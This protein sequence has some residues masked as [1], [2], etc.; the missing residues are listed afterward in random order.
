MVEPLRPKSRRM[1]FALLVTVC[2]VVAVGYG[3][4]A[5]QRTRSES[6]RAV[7]AGAPEVE[8][9]GD[10]AAA[11]A[12]IGKS[13]TVL[14]R[15]EVTGD[16]WAKTA[17][18]P[19][20]A[21]AGS[22]AIVPLRCRRL[23]F[24]GGRGLC[25]ADEPGFG[26]SHEV[27]VFGSDFQVTHKLALSGLPSRARVSP[28]GRY[29]ATTV[30]VAGH[31]YA[32]DD[33][34]TETTILD[35]VNGKKLGT[36][37]EF[38]V[39][40]DGRTS[41][42]VDFN[43]WGVTFAPDGNRFYATLKTKGQTYLVEGDVAARQM[44]VLR[45]N[46]ECPSLSPDG[47]RVAFKKR[48]GGIG[49]GRGPVSWRFHVLD[50]RTMTETPLA[51]DRSIDDQIEWLDDRFVLYGVLADVW[52]VP[53]DGRGEPRRYVSRAA[54]PAVIRTAMNAPLPRETRTLTLAPSDI[55]VAMSAAPNPVKVGQ[56]LTYTVTVSN[57]GPAAATQL[58]LDVRLSPAASFSNFAPVT[59]P[60]IPYGCYVETEYFSCTVDR[61]QARATWTLQF[62]VKP[63]AAGP[64]SH[65]VTVGEAQPDPVPGNNSATVEVRVAP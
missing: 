34:S 58:G 65:R 39:L 62:I 42:A 57:E 26:M 35:L 3:A 63:N 21:P 14:F 9:T 33:F 18:V 52:I 60:R 28:D 4:R 27:S 17:L 55:A 15:N 53:A 1:A 6:G 29:G 47:T 36:L 38:T 56:D 54:S 49:G 46:V 37:E 61:L 50:L 41:K 44:R 8:A 45:P 40:R 64:L 51:E 2:L 48:I 20:T 11:R 12:L 32:G 43:F 16:N 13:A 22:R 7:V 19:V 59:E 24:S 10:S 31:S 5:V 23:H 25:L 30:F